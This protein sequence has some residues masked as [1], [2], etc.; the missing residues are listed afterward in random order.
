MRRTPSLHAGGA[1]IVVALV[2]LML[3]ATTCE[4]GPL[5]EQA[6]CRV[7]NSRGNTT[8]AGSGTLIDK[9]ED[10]KAGLV[11]TCYHLF[12]DGTGDVTVTFKDG[13]QHG[14]RVINYDK[15]ADLAAIEIKNPRAQPVNVII[16]DAPA[17]QLYGYGYGSGRFA[18]QRGR[19]IGTSNSVGQISIIT[20]PGQARS[21]DSGGGLFNSSDQLVGVIWGA[22]PN[23]PNTYACFRTPLRNFLSRVLQRRLTR[24]VIDCP[25]GNCRRPSLVPTPAPPRVV[26][27]A[28]TQPRCQD[29]DCNRER[30]ILTQKLTELSARIESLESQLSLV[31]STPGPPGPQGPPGPPGI[32]GKDA[33]EKPFYIRVNRS[34]PYQP[35]N[36]GQYVTLPLDKIVAQ[37]QH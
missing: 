2:V 36:L 3:L 8:D 17:G 9:T 29:C 30:S 19:F 32:P 23:P 20:G 24:V 31:Q 34:S 26:V 27:P 28:P 33:T 10:G 18:I 35:V 11:L 14:G 22:T 1:W 4:G 15:D 16:T 12:S 5:A 21:G 6:S 37:A 13:S 25:D 7:T